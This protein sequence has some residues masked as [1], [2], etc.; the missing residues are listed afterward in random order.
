MM[1]V[2]LI[3]FIVITTAAHIRWTMPRLFWLT[4]MGVSLIAGC[5]PL[6][7]NAVNDIGALFA[8]ILAAVAVI[9]C[10]VVLV[11]GD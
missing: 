1:H 7:L 5:A 3:T 11:N 10:L 4:I 8:M 9:T 2:L 6:V